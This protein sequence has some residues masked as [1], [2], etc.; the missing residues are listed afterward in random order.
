MELNPFDINSFI[1]R[2]DNSAKTGLNGKINQKIDFGELMTK[3]KTVIQDFFND[4]GLQDLYKNKSVTLLFLDKIENVKGQFHKDV[5]IASQYTLGPSTFASIEMM[6][7]LMEL[8][9]DPTLNEE[10]KT[11][12]ETWIAAESDCLQI[13]LILDRWCSL[14]SDLEKT[15]N[16][17]HEKVDL[18]QAEKVELPAQEVADFTEALS[19]HMKE[20]KP[21]EIFKMPA[22]S[23]IHWTRLRFQKINDDTFDI[24]HYNTGDGATK[25]QSGPPSVS[26]YS[27][28]PCAILEDPK[29]WEQ[30][31]LAKMQPKMDPLNEILKN[32]NVK[33]QD[34]D[35]RFKKSMQMSDSCSFHSVG[36]DFKHSFISHFESVE[37]G[38]DEYKK[39]MS[40][41]PLIAKEHLS[42]STNIDIKRMLDEKVMIRQRDRHWMELINSGDKEKVQNVIN[43]YIEAITSLNKSKDK[44][45][46]GIIQNQSP[47]RCLYLLD[48]LLD[49]CLEKSTFEQLSDIRQRFGENCTF[50]GVNYLGLK[51]MMWFES[52]REMLWNEIEESK[53]VKRKVINLISELSSTIM[54]LSAN[55]ALQEILAPKLDNE[56]LNELL[57]KYLFRES[58]AVA[59]IIL[60]E[61]LDNNFNINID[62]IYS[63]SPELALE[64]VDK[65]QNDEDK[66]FKIRQLIFIISK[67]DINSTLKL[68][69]KIK[70]TPQKID[71]FQRALYYTRAPNSEFIS[72]QT[73]EYALKL[74][75]E[76]KDSNKRDMF[77]SELII[78]VCRNNID[79]AEKLLEEIND[80]SE[81]DRTI[82][83]AANALAHHNVDQAFRLLDK[84]KDVQDFEGAI[85]IVIINASKDNIGDDLE[86]IEKK[87]KDGSVIYSTFSDL[88]LHYGDFDERFQ[89]FIPEDKIDLAVRLFNK[90]KFDS[91]QEKDAVLRFLV[92][93]IPKNHIE[94]A[95]D[96]LG[97]MQDG[98]EKDK[99]KKSLGIPF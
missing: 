37:E 27:G 68:F 64:Y 35:A 53:G 12:I 77:L 66:F 16:S 50:K 6:R 61:L 80:D 26:K 24:I 39:V 90:M 65:I 5:S 25:V 51:Q 91:D 19:N 71:I 69:D 86:L 84:V 44:E 9:K 41:L 33:P 58:P 40:S 72:E 13:C 2:G 20:M 49:T 21:G 42:P 85:K 34:L 17:I 1:S 73:I 48:N 45:I 3:S 43:T 99:A 15:V 8:K 82:K 81:R 30:L 75:E 29:F 32:L 56:A 70:D 94:L 67:E 36:A 22:G 10:A 59:V 98:V 60:R 47:L 23:L 97:Q 92:V 93:S 63:L 14:N 62:L 31:I 57:G 78:A 54:P 11:A 76:I 55:D 4:K 7:Y 18:H 38:W 83:I 46:N 87:I 89:Y 88:Y 74:M 95:Q 79:L 52:N 28:V 96:L